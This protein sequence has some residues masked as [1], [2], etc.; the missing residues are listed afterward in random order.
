[1]TISTYG[2]PQKG[3]NN[4]NRPSP[5]KVSPT[6]PIQGIAQYGD[7]QNNRQVMTQISAIYAK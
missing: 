2:S 7:G 6:K 1:M 5:S 4:S 3:N